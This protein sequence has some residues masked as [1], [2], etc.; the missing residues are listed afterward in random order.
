MKISAPLSK[1]ALNACYGGGFQLHCSSVALPLSSQSWLF[2]CLTESTQQIAGRCV[3]SW[4][5]QFCWTPKFKKTLFAD[6]FRFRLSGEK[7]YDGYIG[8]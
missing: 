6:H 1:L 5:K 8:N 7:V 3:Q 2:D 4:G